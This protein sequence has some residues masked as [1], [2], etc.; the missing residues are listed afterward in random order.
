MRIGVLGGG[1]V[2]TTLA[3]A[4]ARAGHTVHLGSGHPQRAEL[5]E[6]STTSSIPVTTFADAAEGSEVVVNA[7]AGT[8][9]VEVL[10][11]LADL[12]D[13]K[14]LLD[15]SN[16]LDF[17]AGFPPSLTVANTDSLAE[18]VQRSAPGARVVKALNTV[19]AAVMVAPGALTEPTNLPIA[20]DDPEAKQLVLDLLGDLGW[21]GP[22]VLDLGPLPAAR[23]MEAY[24]LLWVRLLGNQQS[25][26]FNIRI[27]TAG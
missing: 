5:Q 13:G 2:G 11:P 27:V 24:L 3:A 23:G 15:V 17:S 8:A 18:R 21:E 10:S 16:P 4:W 14:V 26:M 19:T 20:G 25:P 7:I 6:W 22:D 1:T 12:I 9:A